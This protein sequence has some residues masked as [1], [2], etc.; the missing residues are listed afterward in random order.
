MQRSLTTLACAALLALSLSAH[1]E[2]RDQLRG[3]ASDI[4]GL[5]GMDGVRQWFERTFSASELNALRGE[6]LEVTAQFCN[7]NDRP[8]PH[9]PYVMMLLATPKGDLIARLERSEMSTRVVPIAVRNGDQYCSAED[10]EGCYG[11][12]A[13]A[14]AFTDFRYGPNLAPYFPDC[15]RRSAD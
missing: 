8:D 12:F 9:Y 7:C 4:P 3:R 5:L 15:K 14:C 2:S 6:D 1:A 11:A 10:G 13:H